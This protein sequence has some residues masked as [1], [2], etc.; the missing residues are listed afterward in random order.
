MNY[1][2]LKIILKWIDEKL[3]WVLSVIS[4]VMT[5]LLVLILHSQL[6]N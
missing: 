2:W 4:F 1:N 3:K 5:S 6:I